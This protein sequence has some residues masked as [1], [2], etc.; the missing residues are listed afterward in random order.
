MPWWKARGVGA[1]AEEVVA[2]A[3]IVG[4]DQHHDAHPEERH[5]EAVQTR[6]HTHGSSVNEK[7]SCSP[8]SKVN[9]S[10]CRMGCLRQTRI[11]KTAFEEKA[12]L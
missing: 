10:I 11:G 7:L 2:A 5:D 4:E 3:A 8:S 12:G 6:L 1:P 9:S